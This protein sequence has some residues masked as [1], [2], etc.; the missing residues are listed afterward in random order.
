[1][2][3]EHNEESSE[4][5]RQLHLQLDPDRFSVRMNSSHIVF[6]S[7]YYIP[8]VAVI[9]VEYL[10]LRRGQPTELEAYREPLPFVAEV[11]SRS[12]GGHDVDAKFPVYRERGDVEIWRAHPYSRIVT[13]WRRQLDGTYGE[14]IL[15]N[16]SVTLHGLPGVVINLERL[17]RFV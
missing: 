7:D 10:L 15:D 4:L 11:W 3:M 6:G 16:G 13:A 17:F 14:V 2:T 1:M 12:T 5:V 8:D 9:G